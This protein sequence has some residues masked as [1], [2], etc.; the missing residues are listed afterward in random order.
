[1]GVSGYFA[2]SVPL[3]FWRLFKGIA[4]TLPVFDLLAL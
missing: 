4:G 3:T 2:E 1:V